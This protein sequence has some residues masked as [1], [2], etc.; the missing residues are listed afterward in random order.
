M[1]KSNI[2]SR[3][4]LSFV[5]TSDEPG[6]VSNWK[7]PHD[8]GGYVGDTVPIGHRHFS[9]VAELAEVNE[10]Q[11][12]YAILAAINSPEWNHT[13]DGTGWGIECGFTERLAA[14]AVIGLRAM[15]EG[16]EPYPYQAINA[17]LSK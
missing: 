11:A 14:A 15:R 7:V 17:E 5:A 2:T 3:R 4:E 1:T 12:F 16:A 8:K 6:I 13:K 10:H 9:E